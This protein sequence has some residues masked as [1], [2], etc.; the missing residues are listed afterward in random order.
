MRF[1]IN[2][3]PSKNYQSQRKNSQKNPWITTGILNSI[4]N[5]NR[6]YRKVIRAKDPVRITNLRNKFKL[7]RNKLD[8]ILKASKSMHYQKYFETNRLN[9]R[10]TWDGIREVINIRKKKGKQ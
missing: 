10:K 5:K 2:M 3:H 8:K 6:L 7:Y 1:L 9:L 4:K